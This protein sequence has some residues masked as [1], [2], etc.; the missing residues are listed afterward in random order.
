M[1]HARGVSAILM[2][3]PSPVELVCIGH[4]FELTDPLPLKQIDASNP[5][6]K[7]ASSLQMSENFSILYTPLVNA[8]RP[9]LDVI[10][11]KTQSLVRRMGALLGSEATAVADFQLLE[12]EAK[13]LIGDYVKW[14]MSLSKEWGPRTVGIISGKCDSTK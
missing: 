9:T 2:S 1:A 3:K 6:S 4:L 8:S 11:V 14:E 10:F 5:I 12:R 13:L 7:S